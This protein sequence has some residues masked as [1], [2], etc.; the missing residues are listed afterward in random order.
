MLLRRVEVNV[1]LTII[2]FG[3]VLRPQAKFCHGDRIITDD[4][5]QML[6][7]WISVS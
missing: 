1:K 2:S 5:I 3:L 7:L 6:G 4:E